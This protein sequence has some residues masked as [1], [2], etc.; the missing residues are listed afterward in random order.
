MQLE[1]THLWLWWLMILGNARWCEWTGD[2]LK[3]W[4]F[5]GKTTKEKPREGMHWELKKKKKRRG[6]LEKP[7]V[8]CGLNYSSQSCVIQR[9]KYKSPQI[10]SWL[11][12]IHFVFPQELPHLSSYVL[13]SP[14]TTSVRTQNSQLRSFV[15]F[16]YSWA[17][18]IL[19]HFAFGFYLSL[20]Q[21]TTAKHHLFTTAYE[22]SL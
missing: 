8:W 10:L 3:A 4:M 19:A 21:K 15:G 9:I 20:I 16:L 11:H 18:S 12:H 1:P 7:T 17:S 6:E 13:S 14:T 2:A 5:T 22:V